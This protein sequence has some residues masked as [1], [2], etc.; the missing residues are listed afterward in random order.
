MDNNAVTSLFMFFV[1][2]TLIIIAAYYT[3]K[4]IG[5]KAAGFSKRKHI[6]LLEK[7]NLPGNLSI[8]V[9][10]VADQVYLLAC[11]GKDVTLLDRYSMDQWLEM[12]SADKI[13]E[14]NE[15][16]KN[17]FNPYKDRIDSFRKRFLMDPYEKNE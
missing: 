6:S 12:K 17:N 7:N 8:E 14:F 2:T 1:T 16:S 11:R 3:T 5:Q 4:F 15:P 13:M 9:V 10:K